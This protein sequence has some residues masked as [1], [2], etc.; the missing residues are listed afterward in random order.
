MSTDYKEWPKVWYLL[1][2]PVLI[3]A[4]WHLALVFSSQLT[5]NTVHHTI[6]MNGTVVTTTTTGSNGRGLHFPYAEPDT[7]VLVEKNPPGYPGNVSD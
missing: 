6:T 2:L 3:V 1:L 5:Q 4:S 7:Y